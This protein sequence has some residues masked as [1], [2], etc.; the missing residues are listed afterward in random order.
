MTVS[1]CKNRYRAFRYGKSFDSTLEALDALAL[2]YGFS[3]GRMLRI[4][5]NWIL[6][7][8]E[9][10]KAFREDLESQKLLYF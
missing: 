5:L 10:V 1:S 8:D 2:E 4:C 7:N 6:N 9:R 3:N